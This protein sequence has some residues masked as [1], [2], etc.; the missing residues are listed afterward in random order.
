VAEHSACRETVTYIE[1]ALEALQHLP[2][3][4]ETLQQAID[5]RLDLRHAFFALGAH[6]PMFD[7]LR[8]AEVLAEALR[9]QHRLGQVSTYLSQYY[10]AMGDQERAL[11]SGRRAL[12]CAERLGDVA[13]QGIATIYLSQACHALGEYHQ[14]IAYIRKSIVSFEGEQRRARFGL[15]YLPSVF[16]RNLL[17]FY[18]AIV[19]AFVESIAVGEEGVQI[20]ETTDHALSRI[21]AYNGIGFAYFYKGDLH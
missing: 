20:A 2:E 16:S 17:T 3:S 13:L 5:L 10:W 9:D 21:S 12:A 6:R 15:P 4:R 7:P 18:L 11:V 19:G 8:E 14:A 1:Q